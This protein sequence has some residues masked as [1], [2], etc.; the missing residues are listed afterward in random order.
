MGTLAG[1]VEVMETQGQVS[2][3]FRL[4][5]WPGKAHELVCVDENLR[6]KWVALGGFGIE[7]G[8]C[9]SA[10]CPVAVKG[11]ERQVACLRINQEVV[12]VD[13]DVLTDLDESLFAVRIGDGVETSARRL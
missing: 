7:V 13:E 4:P 11:L 2:D 3:G 1:A 5:L 8:H 10:G 12:S 9:K 6:R